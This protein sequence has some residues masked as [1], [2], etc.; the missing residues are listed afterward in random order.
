MQEFPKWK[1][2]ATNAPV[3]VSDP[4][5]EAELGPDWEDTPAAFNAKPEDAKPEAPKKGK[6]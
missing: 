3:I 6:K 1:Y 2:H 5:K 4:D